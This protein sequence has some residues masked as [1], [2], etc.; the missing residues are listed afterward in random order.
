MA[1]FELPAQ[2]E[3]TELTR[4]GLDIRSNLLPK[5]EYPAIATYAATQTNLPSHLGPLSDFQPSSNPLP[6]DISSTPSAQLSADTDDTS[7]GTDSYPDQV[8]DLV[9]QSYLSVQHAYELDLLCCLEPEDTIEFTYVDANENLDGPVTG[10]P[11]S[12][13]FCVIPTPSGRKLHNTEPDIHRQQAYPL[14]P[15]Q[16]RAHRDY[17]CVS[18]TGKVPPIKAP[19]VPNTGEAPNPQPPPMPLENG[20]TTP[21]PKEN[22]ETE[23]PGPPGPPEPHAPPDGPPLIPPEPGEATTPTPHTDPS[24]PSARPPG[25]TIEH[26]TQLARMSHT[27]LITA[28]VGHRLTYKILTKDTHQVIYHSKVRPTS[29]AHHRHLDLLSGEDLVGGQKIKTFKTFIQSKDENQSDSTYTDETDDNKQ[30]IATAKLVDLISNTFLMNQQENGTQHRARI[31]ELIEDHE[32]NVEKDPQ[33]TRFKVSSNTDQYEETLA[34]RQVL[35]HILQDENTGIVWKHNQIVGYQG[36]LNSKCPDHNGSS[37]NM[38]VQWEDESISH[39][40]LCMLA[41]NDPV[42]SAVYAND[43]SLLDTPG[44]IRFKSIDRVHKKYIIVVNQAKPHSHR[45]TPKYMFGY[46]VPRD[47]KHV[48]DQIIENSNFLRHLSIEAKQIPYLF[49][50]NESV[51]NIASTPTARLNKRHSSLSF[52]RTRGTIAAGFIR[53]HHIT[54][55]TNPAD[56]L[57]KHWAHQAI[58]PQLQALM[59]LP[60]DIGKL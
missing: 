57:S 42:A 4:E 37:Y 59:F 48:G 7:T 33:C 35:D 53:L 14:T 21:M 8:D 22:G 39:V 5:E 31:S 19:T 56:I 52:H 50:D 38:I 29:S 51:V 16:T 18:T 11:S 1:P 45:T 10:L 20:E 12:N 23:P 60:G 44:W 32:G 9:N 27:E 58:W 28:H 30:P 54:G 13:P 24:A 3:P 43:H 40:P 34:H 47:F 15:S 46:K 55:E 41:A 49:D 26:T 17:S 25:N 36:L 6:D 2:R